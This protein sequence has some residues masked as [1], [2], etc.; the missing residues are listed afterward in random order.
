[1]GLGVISQLQDHHRFPPAE[2][3][4]V[5]A[6]AIRSVQQRGDRAKID[7][8]ELEQAQEQVNAYLTFRER[9]FQR[10]QVN[11][12]LSQLQMERREG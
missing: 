6:D 3:L 9:K 1:M 10:Q 7:V 4:S 5:V 8:E 2:A 12:E 11:A